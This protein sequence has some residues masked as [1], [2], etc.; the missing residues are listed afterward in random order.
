MKGV[1]GTCEGT[2]RILS[3]LLWKVTLQLNPFSG[4]YIRLCQCCGKFYK[5]VSF[6][7]FTF[8]TSHSQMT[9]IFLPGGHS[10]CF[11][12]KNRRETSPANGGL[13]LGLMNWSLNF[14]ECWVSH[15]SILDISCLPR[16][17]LY[18]SRHSNG[19]PFPGG[20]LSRD[21]FCKAGAPHQ[22]VCALCKIAPVKVSCQK[23]QSHLS[24]VKLNIFSQIN[25]KCPKHMCG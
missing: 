3:A 18:V 13:F 4:S 22:G 19:F 14:A 8:E 24:T 7:N 15:M 12:L 16:W 11:H 5:S 2:I 25:K 17:K 10:T 21:L 23:K 1:C 20:E 6:V 9:L